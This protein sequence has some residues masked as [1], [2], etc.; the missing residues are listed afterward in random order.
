MCNISVKRARK[1]EEGRSRHTRALKQ[2][3]RKRSERVEF[4]HLR[5]C[6]HY[7]DVVVSDAGLESHCRREAAHDLPCNKHHYRR[8]V[9][10]LTVSLAAT[11]LHIRIDQRTR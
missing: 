9:E 11:E 4:V 7:H 3:Y 1:A 8:V 6:I 2:V 10:R 5:C